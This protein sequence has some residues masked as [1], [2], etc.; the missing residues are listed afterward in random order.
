[1]PVILAPG[2]YARWLGDEPA[3]ATPCARSRMWPISTRVK[4][5]IF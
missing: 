2:D 1:M 5:L 4:L 3:L